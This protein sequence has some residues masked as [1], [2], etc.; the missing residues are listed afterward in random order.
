[1]A[2]TVTKEKRSWIMSRVR[3]KNTKPEILLRSLLH[4]S[5]FRFRL[6]DEKLPGKPDIVLPRY[7]AVIFVNGCF[8]HRHKGC[9]VSRIPKSH[10]DFWINKFNKNIQRDRKHQQK[11]ERLGWQV[12]IVWEC[13]LKESQIS[14]ISNISSHLLSTSIQ[15]AKKAK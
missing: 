2:D 13:E 14:V 9:K 4:R 15:T 6:H 1:M 7:R 10:R 5:G 3:G 12:L 11:L 8:W